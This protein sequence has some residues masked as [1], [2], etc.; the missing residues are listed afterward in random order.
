MKL[1]TRVEQLEHEVKIL[2]NEI[3]HTLLEIQEQILIH[4]YPALRAAESEDTNQ[5]AAL[6][7]SLR[8]KQRSRGGTE[9]GN[10][11]DFIGL[12]NGADL[13]AESL[14]RETWMSMPGST[15]EIAGHRSFHTLFP[16]QT[17]PGEN[18]PEEGGTD[19]SDAQIDE[20][21]RQSRAQEVSLDDIRRKHAGHYTETAHP[22][23]SARTPRHPHPAKFAQL[24]DWVAETVRKV[25]KE[26][27]KKAVETYAAGGYIPADTKEMIFQ[28]IALADDETLWEPSGSTDTIE[29]L[30]HLDNV[31]SGD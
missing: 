1:E 27:A 7:D 28:L 5:M 11:S 13:D 22:E 31:L 17:A 3:Q 25:G 19:E 18:S 20:F 26:R 30:V 15:G 21:A 12:G 23:P 14:D 29:V 2:K 16:D 10:G 24:A 9:Q 4:Y 6:L 8:T